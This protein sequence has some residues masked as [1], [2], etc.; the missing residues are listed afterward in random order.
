MLAPLLPD[1]K[2]GGRLE[3][4][5]DIPAAPAAIVELLRGSLGGA[6]G[7][8]DKFVARE[9]LGR[10]RT[11]LIQT[12]DD[13]ILRWAKVQ[14]FYRPLLAANSGSTR[15]PNRVSALRQRRP[16]V[17]NISPSRLR[18]IAMPWYSLR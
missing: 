3:R 13:A 6:F 5:E 11:H 1:A 7:H 2:P 9:A 18:F 16:S 4:A 10:F 15:S 8:V 17:R 12:H 14:R